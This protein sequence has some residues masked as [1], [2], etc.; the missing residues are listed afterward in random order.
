MS[1]RSPFKPTR[2]LTVTGT[3][4]LF[5]C[6]LT[7]IG[8][9]MP[10]PLGPGLSG[11]GVE[12]RMDRGALSLSFQQGYQ[13]N[14]TKA[15]IKQLRVTLSGGPLTTAQTQTAAY[16]PSANLSFKSI[17]EGTIAVKVECLDAAG[18]VIG[19][20]T[21]TGVAIIAGQ[22][23]SVSV[24]IKLA[25]TQVDPGTGNVGVGII[26][27]DGDIVTTPLP[28]PAP[29]TAPTA[30]PRPTTSPTP[31]PTTAPSTAIPALPSGLKTMT[32][33]MGSTPGAN[34]QKAING[35]ASTGGIINIP[36]GT[37][38]M[39][40]QVYLKS[41][42]HLV[43]VAGQTIL[44]G[45]GTRTILDGAN[46][47]DATIRTL[48]LDANENGNLQRAFVAT[49][50]VRLGVFNCEIKNTGADA[51]GIEL[52][53]NVDHAKLIGNY[54]HDVGNAG[55][56]WGTGITLGWDSSDAVIT[57]NR[58]ENASRAG[59]NAHNDCK[60]LYVAR[61]DVRKLGGE[62]LGIELWSNCSGTVENNKVSSW[63]SFDGASG[64]IQNNEV[65]GTW[66][67]TT[68]KYG[69]EV[70]SGDGVKV[71]NNRVT[72]ARMGISID[73]SN[74]CL[75]Q[76]NV[77]DGGET[78][79]QGYGATSPAKYNQLISNTFKNM[80]GRALMLNQNCD[81]WKIDR[82]TIDHVG[83]SGIYI[84]GTDDITI[85]NNTIAYT[86]Q[87]TSSG[88][89]AIYWNSDRKTKL[90]L[91][92]NTLSNNKTNYANIPSQFLP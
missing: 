25:P 50:A 62:G 55:D 4:L 22:L 80:S 9:G 21:K 43:G 79:L 23:T 87:T 76:G 61:N 30:T 46:T 51:Y 91:S 78:G 56:K 10:S 2:R 37:Y 40:T 11:D 84:Y 59:I 58:I 90:V 13:T 31:A 18:A 19:T 49:N 45:A 63:I 75:F 3:A 27:D 70:V 52:Q 14:A 82:N 73:K 66:N 77:I 85:T 33:T 44:K 72:A 38:N 81:G 17:P 15:D 36:A 32:V 26:I 29:T 20:T 39:E 53:K 8:C 12:Q 86:G 47:T 5:A 83:K 89:A 7:L 68:P 41:N 24:Q 60:N 16:P 34:L 71:L 92:G 6:S 28:T 57:D 69:I 64:V 88:E 54:I 35:L 42:V 48:V 1:F 65:N 67:P 74:N